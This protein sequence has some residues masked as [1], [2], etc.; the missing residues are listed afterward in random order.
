MAMNSTITSHHTL[1]D[2]KGAET[3]TSVEVNSLYTD[4]P[5]IKISG[6]NPDSG[7]RLIIALTESEWVF[8]VEAVKNGMDL[9]YDLKT[10]TGVEA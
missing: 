8:V 10:R 2:E 5:Q 6:S 1:L 4:S 7:D 9:Y 3:D